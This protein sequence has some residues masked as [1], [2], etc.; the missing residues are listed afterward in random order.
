MRTVR[1]STSDATG[2]LGLTVAPGSRKRL[3]T[4][5]STGD[6]DGRVRQV[7]LQFVEPR[8]RLLELR[9]REIDLRDRG[10][11][12]RLGVVVG[13]LGS[14]CRSSRLSFRSRFVCASLRSASRCRM[15][16][17]EHL[18]GRFG[19]ADLLLDLAIL[20]L[21]DV[22]A[23]THRSPSRTLTMQ[24]S[25]DPGNGLDGRGANQVADDQTRSATG[26]AATARTPP[27]SAAAHHR[28]RVRRPRQTARRVATP[29]C[30]HCSRPR[31]RVRA[32]RPN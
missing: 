23:A 14:S 17:C 4:K 26:R 25:V 12:T 28:R 30:H 10:L 8:L 20:D 22:L 21:G 11:V 1:I 18:E 2:T 32:W 9:L 24:P 31:P 27:A 16:A 5:P 15:V 3:A 29:R 13:L 6:D 7:D 19:L